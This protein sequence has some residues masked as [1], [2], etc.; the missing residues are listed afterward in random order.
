MQGCLQIGEV[1]FFFQAHINAQVM[2]LALVSLFSER[3]EALFQASHCT[4]WSCQ[5]QGSDRLLVV[6]AKSIMSVVAMI[7]Y[8]H[9]QDDKCYVLVE[10]LGLDVAYLSGS[11]SDES[12]EGGE[13]ETA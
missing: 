10:K 9:Q 13:P 12:R 3:D 5:Y 8:H 7:P 11:T 4:V 6:E 2:T 1:Q